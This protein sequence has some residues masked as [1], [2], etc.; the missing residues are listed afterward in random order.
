MMESRRTG[1]WWNT[2]GDADHFEGL[3][4]IHS[5]E[6]N[7]EPKKRLFIAPERVYH[8]GLVK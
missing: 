4:E 2:H 3:T 8:N 7:K 6:S 5:S 1:G